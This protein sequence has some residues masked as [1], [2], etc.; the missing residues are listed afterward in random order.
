MVAGEI[1]TR[2]SSTAAGRSPK[3]WIYPGSQIGKIAFRRF[4]QVRF[5]VSQICFKGFRISPS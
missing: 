5:A 4:E 3:S 2:A 1:F